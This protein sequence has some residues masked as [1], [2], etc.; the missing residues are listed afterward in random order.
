MTKI[1][2][3]NDPPRVTLSVP[4]DIAIEKV[5]EIANVIMGWN[6]T[7][8]TAPK[9][10][11]PISTEPKPQANA[12]T[13]ISTKGITLPN[14]GIAIVLMK[15]EQVVKAKRFYKDK[16]AAMEYYDQCPHDGDQ[17]ARLVLNGVT[18]NHE[19]ALQYFNTD[20]RKKKTL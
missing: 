19:Q 13:A 7:T 15:G 12:N 16:S 9:N 2:I 1:S 4:D 18:Y 17:C 11:K 8:P 5:L 20:Q 3:T 6:I 14:V 10:H